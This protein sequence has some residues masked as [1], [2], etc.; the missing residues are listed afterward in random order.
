MRYANQIGPLE[1]EA[2][3][4]AIREQIGR[5]VHYGGAADNQQLPPYDDMLLDDDE[6]EE[7]RLQ[8]QQG[9]QHRIGMITEVP[10]LSE[11]LMS[12]GPRMSPRASWPPFC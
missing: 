5:G 7:F 6:R 4:H 9:Q 2:A 12:M 3:R 8:R 10:L 1:R 11:P